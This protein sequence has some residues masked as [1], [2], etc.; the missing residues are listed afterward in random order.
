MGKQK[1]VDFSKWGY[2]FIAPFFICFLIFSLI[3]L[4]DTIRFSFFEYFSSGL[5][6]IGPNWVGLANYV[7]LATT[8]L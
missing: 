5:K 8:D 4:A 7:A 1:R 2:I 6:E 3:P